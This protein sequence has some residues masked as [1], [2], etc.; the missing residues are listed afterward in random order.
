MFKRN[1]NSNGWYA[2]VAYLLPF[3][4]G[5]K[6][7]IEPNFRY[8]EFNKNNS[9]SGKKINATSVGLNFYIRGH[10]LKAQMDYTLFGEETNALNN[11]V[12]EVQLQFDF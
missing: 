5:K 7:K 12:F 3:E 9:I 6:L 4:I 1:V 10:N 2:Q 8:Q 11:N